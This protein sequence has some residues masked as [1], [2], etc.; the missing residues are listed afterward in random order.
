MREQDRTCSAPLLMAEWGWGEERQKTGQ[1]LR[2][3]PP[4][5]TLKGRPEF[6]QYKGPYQASPW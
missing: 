3:L 5:L 2:T 1:G 4:S 6:W